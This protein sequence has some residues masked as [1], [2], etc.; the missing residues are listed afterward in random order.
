MEEIRESGQ[1]I[2]VAIDRDLADL[3]PKYLENRKNDLARL[4]ELLGA[5]RQIE[6]PET[7]EEA[8]RILHTMK[9]SGGSYGFHEITRLARAME[10]FLSAKNFVELEKGLLGLESFLTHLRV[11]YVEET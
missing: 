4:R 6:T 10:T 2:V 7:L 1:P 3:I 11:E 5:G 9:G 8:G